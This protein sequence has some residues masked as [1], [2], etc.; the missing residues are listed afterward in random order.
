M[1]EEAFQLSNYWEDEQGRCRCSAVKVIKFATLIPHPSFFWGCSKYTP[2][3]VYSHDKG[4]PIK[5]SC[6]TILDPEGE[7]RGK[8][9]NMSNKELD[10]LSTKYRQLRMDNLQLVEK[11][12]D[13]T[14]LVYTECVSK[15]H[16]VGLK[17]R[18]LKTGHT[19]RES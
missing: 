16:Q 12:G 5:R 2:V 8:T 14:Q 19:S 18:K 11:Q 1:G 4:I 7:N 9:A 3:D 6:W 10:R 15:K 17:H 13:H